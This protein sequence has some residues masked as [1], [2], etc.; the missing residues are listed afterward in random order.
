MNIDRELLLDALCD[1][2]ADEDA[3]RED[4]SGRGMYGDTC[5]G[6]VL[7]GVSA[8]ARFLIAVAA[9]SS[10]DAAWLADNVVV[11]NMGRSMIYYFPGVK[12]TVPA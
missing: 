7:S 11:D 9:E 6:V 3:L 5:I 8:F 1:A 2:G 10:D 12:V 4:Y